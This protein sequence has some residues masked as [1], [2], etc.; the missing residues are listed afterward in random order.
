MHPGIKSSLHR[1]LVPRHSWVLG[2]ES[3]TW[4]TAANGTEAAWAERGRYIHNLLYLRPSL[5]TLIQQSQRIQMLM[6]IRK[7]TKRREGDHDSAPMLY[8]SLCTYHA[9]GGLFTKISI[10][11]ANQFQRIFEK[12]VVQRKQTAVIK[13]VTK[14]STVLLP[15]S[16]VG[17]VY[18]VISFGDTPRPLNLF[19][20]FLQF[21]A[22][23]GSYIHQ[24]IFT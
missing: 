15:H 5:A 23:R 20:I 14:N 19:L 18:G 10:F 12:K 13:K 22:L 6:M 7:R 24:Y 21:H 17:Q 3:L 2:L 1:L 8:Y 9:S 16:R 11:N 4:L